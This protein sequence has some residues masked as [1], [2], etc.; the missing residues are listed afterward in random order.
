MLLNSAN[1]PGRPILLWSYII[2]VV[3]YIM[4]VKPLLCG[5]DLLVDWV[6]VVVSLGKV[7]DGWV[8]TRCY[9]W[10]VPVVAPWLK[11]LTSIHEDTGSIPSLAQ[12]VKDLVLP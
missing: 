5:G 4:T 6:T 7:S 10:G 9:V 11:N 12:R 1:D 8:Y 2:M 3:L